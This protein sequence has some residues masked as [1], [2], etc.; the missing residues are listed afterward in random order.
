[1]SIIS[2]LALSGAGS[3]GPEKSGATG[4]QT[5]GGGSGPS[6]GNATDA[7]LAPR[8]GSPVIFIDPQ[9][10][11]VIYEFRDAQSG[12]LDY[13]IPSLS[14]VHRYQATQD[15]TLPGRTPSAGA[16]AGATTAPTAAFTA[17]GVAT[18]TAST[19]A[20]TPAAPGASISA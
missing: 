12:S 5:A 20:A 1:M 4:G 16:P 3:L 9:S 8:Y 6:G 7:S 19:G 10:S 11:Q 14:S 13:T 17:S 2:S 18:A 15:S